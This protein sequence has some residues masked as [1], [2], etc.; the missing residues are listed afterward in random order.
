MILLA[1]NRASSTSDGAAS[2]FYEF[3]INH[4]YWICGVRYESQYHV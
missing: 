1:D 4:D 2:E 3:A